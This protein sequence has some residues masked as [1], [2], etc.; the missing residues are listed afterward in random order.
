MTQ[1][2][3]SNRGFGAMNPEKQ[4]EIASQGGK[5]AHAKGTARIR[6]QLRAQGGP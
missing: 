5:A 2:N 3:T 6:H 1:Q 4:R